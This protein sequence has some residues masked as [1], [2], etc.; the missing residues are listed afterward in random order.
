M[1]ARCLAL[2]LQAIAFPVAL[3]IA[4]TQTDNVYMSMNMYG[5]GPESVDNLSYYHENFATWVTVALLVGMTACYAL[6]QDM[7]HTSL[8]RDLPDDERRAYLTRY[9]T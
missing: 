4:K 8:I 7:I 3:I 1:G 6:L 9:V 5:T 2:L